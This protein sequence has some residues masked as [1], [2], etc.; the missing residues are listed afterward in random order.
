MNC[1][2]HLQVCSALHDRIS[3]TIFSCL[4][5][6]CEADLGTHLAEGATLHLAWAN[7]VLSKASVIG[8]R[9]DLS[10][11]ARWDPTQ[12]RQERQH[13]TPD[14]VV[15]LAKQTGR[16]SLAHVEDDTYTPNERI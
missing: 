6:V 3:K 2:L 9:D 5:P 8:S 10:T 7:R 14:Q 16:S 12:R 11:W 13:A 4:L 1:T 15:F